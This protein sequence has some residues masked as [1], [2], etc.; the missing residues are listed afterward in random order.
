ML[1]PVNVKYWEKIHSS[2]NLGIHKEDDYAAKCDICGDSM[3]YKNKKRLHLY[4]KI[5]YNDDSIKCFNCGYTGTM[6][7]YLKHFHPEYLGKYIKDINNN[8]IERINLKNSIKKIESKD[9]NNNFV[10]SLPK[11]STNKLA[12]EYIKSRGCNPDD[13][14]YSE[15]SF[16][17]FG[18]KLKLP[19]YIVYFNFFKD[20]PIGLWS[21]S[22]DKKIFYLFCPEGY[23]KLI[24]S[25]DF[26]ASDNVYVFEGLFDML[27]A[28]MKNK[29][30]MLGLGLPKNVLNNIKNI[31][32]CADNDV[33]GYTEMLK[34]TKNKNHKFVIW[35]N[36]K[37]LNCM[38]DIN[39]LYMNGV[40]LN[41]FIKSHTYSGLE[42]EC[43][44]RISN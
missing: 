20:K 21:R 13:F 17:M 34:H 24:Y 44:L 14:Y 5:E 37:S 43:I 28:P 3:H 11:A 38:K 16:E 40:D 22:L 2:D 1:N 27:C 31:V 32:W 35:K 6:Y 8:K 26:N 19:N 9:I 10:I 33:A 23:S 41:E 7:S 12:S 39:E 18:K 42:A 15:D 36:D 25:K 29:I 30:T 4:T